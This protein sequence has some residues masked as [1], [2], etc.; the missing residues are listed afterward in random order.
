[1]SSDFIGTL[2]AGTLYGD[3]VHQGGLALD[4]V[5]GSVH[6]GFT[7]DNS[8]GTLF[9]DQAGFSI[10]FWVRPV[11]DIP[12]YA[13]TLMTNE[14]YPDDGFRL[15]YVPAGSLSQ[16]HSSIRFQTYY[17]GGTLELNSPATHP[18]ELGEWVH[19]AVVHDG[20]TGQLYL[21]GEEVDADSDGMVNWGTSSLKVGHGIG[22]NAPFKGNLDD[23]RIHRG[24]LTPQRVAEL[25]NGTDDDLPDWWEMALFGNL[26]DQD[27][28]T[29]F[30]GDGVLDGAEFLAGSDPK[31]FF[32]RPSGLI[33][34]Q[35]VVMPL[36]PL[37]IT[38]LEPTPIVIKLLDLNSLD[39]SGNPTPVG[40]MPFSWLVTRGNLKASL[41]ADGPAQSIGDFTTDPDSG[42]ATLHLLLDWPASTESAIRLSVGE[43]NTEFIV[44]EAPDNDNLPDEWEIE[45]FGT[46]AFGDDDYPDQESSLHPSGLTLTNLE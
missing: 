9:P 32:D 20:A 1:V 13:N 15:F 29:D 34:P 25:A 28:S 18:V 3:A 7:V 31:N 6:H 27:D 40:G 37:A 45:H 36:S 12:G 42:E 39:G 2:R 21:N 16:A 35:I 5:M 14:T 26:T 44:T 10:S 30:D 41:A 24:A 23:I 38:P 8:A 4:G 19:V 43:L 22:G 11:E 17:G 46:L 33:D